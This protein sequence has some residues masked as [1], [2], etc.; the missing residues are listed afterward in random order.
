MDNITALKLSAKGSYAIVESSDLKRSTHPETF[1][2][3][4]LEMEYT[5]HAADKVLIQQPVTVY[6]PNYGHVTT[7]QFTTIELSPTDLRAIVAKLDSLHK[8]ELKKIIKDD[9]DDLPF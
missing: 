7:G 6:D 2:K 8:V 5:V 9:L 4:P 1:D 3:A